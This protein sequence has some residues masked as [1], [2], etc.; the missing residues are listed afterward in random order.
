MQSELIGMGALYGVLEFLKFIIPK[1]V[2]KRSHLTID[3]SHQLK[4]LYKMHNVTDES[5][6]PIWYMPA[7][8]ADQQE[9]MIGILSDISENMK[10]NQIYQ[11]QTATI[12]DKII[13]RLPK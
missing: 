13:D 10:E 1:V 2:P 11:K 5:G 8:V 4:Q 7:T 12:L 3:E 9:K 6:R